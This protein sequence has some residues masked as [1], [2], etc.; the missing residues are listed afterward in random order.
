MRD[1]TALHL[2]GGADYQHDMRGLV[3]ISGGFGLGPRR[4]RHARTSLSAFPARVLS[5]SHEVP[6]PSRRPPHFMPAASA[7]KSMPQL[8]CYKSITAAIPP[9]AELLPR[10]PSFMSDTGQHTT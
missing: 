2:P 1:Y 4:P 3:A 10:F 5:I 7:G 8:S 9:S 6:P